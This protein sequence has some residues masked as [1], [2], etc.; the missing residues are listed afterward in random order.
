MRSHHA[1]PVFVND[2]VVR[3]AVTTFLSLGLTA[4][5]VAADDESYA[6]EVI[7]VDAAA[8]GVTLGGDAMDR[9]SV[10]DV[11][12]AMSFGGA[13]LVHLA[14]GNRVAAAESL[15]LHITLPLASSLV[16]D[17]IT[18]SKSTMMLAFAAGVVVATAIDASTLA[19]KK[20]IDRKWRPDLAFKD[21]GMRFLIVGKF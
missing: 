1:W 13:P 7:A 8:L 21:G 4:Q 12:I 20:L 18:E 16:V 10:R 15:A 11:G 14:N 17:R 3:V 5:A 2:A 6:K 19:K 9:T